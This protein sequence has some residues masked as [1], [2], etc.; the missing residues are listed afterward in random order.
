[1][2]FPTLFKQGFMIM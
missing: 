2:I 1:V